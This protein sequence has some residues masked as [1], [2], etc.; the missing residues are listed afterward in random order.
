[1]NL[2]DEEGIG[3]RTAAVTVLLLVLDAAVLFGV[4]LWLTGSDSCTGA[5]GTVGLTLLYAGGP[6]SALFGVLTGAVVVAWPVDLI[7]WVVVGFVIS[8]V[9]GD[10]LR[11]AVAAAATVEFVALLYGLALSFLVVRA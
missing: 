7:L 9:A 10:R 5:C 6:V 11:K 1:M 8:R 2:I 3:C 4:G